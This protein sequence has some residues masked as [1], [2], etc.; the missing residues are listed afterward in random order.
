MKRLNIQFYGEEQPPVFNGWT[1]ASALEGDALPRLDH[2]RVEGGY[3]MGDG[4][5]SLV[6]SRSQA[7]SYLYLAPWRVL[8]SKQAPSAVRRDLANSCLQSPKMRS[9]FLDLGYQHSASPTSWDTQGAFGW[10]KEGDRDKMIIYQEEYFRPGRYETCG[11][12]NGH[13]SREMLVYAHEKGVEFS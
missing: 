13:M 6:Q 5:L 12:F 8:N 3:F 4:L 9:C 1:L 11:L 10:H 2:L 7:L